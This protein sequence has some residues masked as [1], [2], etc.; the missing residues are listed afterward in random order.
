L[1]VEGRV[2]RYGLIGH[3]VSHS[4]SQQYF[5]RKFEREGI[6]ARYDLFD[7]PE[8]AALPKLI[9]EHEL[10]G[11]NIT[12]PHKRSAMPFMQ[13]LDDTAKHVGAVNT[14]RVTKTGLV[15]YNTDATGFRSMLLPLIG[16]ERPRALLL[17]TGGASRAVAFVLRELGIRF[18]LVSRDLQRGDITYDM[19]DPIVLKVSPLVINTSPVGQ[20]PDADRAPQLPY[21]ALTPKHLLIDLVYNPDTT[22]FMQHGRKHGARTCNGLPMLHAQAEAAWGIWSS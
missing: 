16:A 18:R 12:I 11:F 22:L 4:S 19:L 9:A 13:A 2:D 5:T 21:D 3:P 14:V 6:H 1:S 20:F 15:G 17:G 10:C 7:L 8:I